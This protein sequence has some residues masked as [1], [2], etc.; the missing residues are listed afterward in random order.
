[1]T[2]T[3]A[4]AQV[5]AKI[6]VRPT[7]SQT[8]L[9]AVAVVA[10]ISLI[11]SALLFGIGQPIAG[12]GFLFLT[13][14]VLWFAFKAWTKSQPDIDME[15]GHPTRFMLPNGTSVS[16]D[17]RTLRSPEGLSGLIRVC[18]EILHR[19]PLPNPDG[20]VDHNLKVIPD[21]KEAAIAT[22]REINANTQTAT[23]TL[24]DILGFEEEEYIDDLTEQ[25]ANNSYSGP[26]EDV[27][28]NLNSPLL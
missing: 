2:S 22:T 4:S 13:P 9:V 16:T 3:G 19:K 23:N 17:S 18:G 10:G 15:K 5:E 11:C 21:S 25:I 12:S 6:N 28:K 14:A 24:I 8:F 26:V 27:P 20:Q 1:M 7:Q